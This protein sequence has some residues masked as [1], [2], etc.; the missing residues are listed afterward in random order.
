MRTIWTMKGGNQ[1]NRGEGGRGQQENMPSRCGGGKSMCVRG[2]ECLATTGG[3]EGG[4]FFP[5]ERGGSNN[6]RG[7]GDQQNNKNGVEGK[8]CGGERGSSG[9][10]SDHP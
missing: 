7:V 6:N 9:G 2:G 3:K 1:I 10:S 8:G 5:E 4:F